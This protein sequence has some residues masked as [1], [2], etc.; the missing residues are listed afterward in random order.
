M[1]IMD[2]SGSEARVH[3]S[4]SKCRGVGQTKVNFFKAPGRLRFGTK[5]GVQVWGIPGLRSSLLFVDRF[6]CLHTFG[7]ITDQSKFI[8]S[9]ENEIHN[10]EFQIDYLHN[11]WRTW[12]MIRSWFPSLVLGIRRNMCFLCYFVPSLGVAGFC[13]EKFEMMTRQ[14]SFPYDVDDLIFEIVMWSQQI[15]PQSLEILQ[16]LIRTNTSQGKTYILSSVQG[17]LAKQINGQSN[18]IKF[19]S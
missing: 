12:N 6:E 11:L 19:K 5:L 15:S 4:F 9:T 7:R 8:H 18:N 1:T 16:N 10:S 13:D 2:A 14:S 17:T 3:V